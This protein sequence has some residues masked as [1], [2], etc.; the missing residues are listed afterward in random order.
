MMKRAFILSV[1]LLAVLSACEG[2]LWGRL[3]TAP[4]RVPPTPGFTPSAENPSPVPYG[5]ATAIS[6][7]TQVR[8]SPLPPTLTLEPQAWK[9]M[10]VVPQVSERM[11]AVYRAGLAA[12]RDPARFSKIGDCQNITTYFLADFDHPGEYRLGS[13]YASLQPTIDH[14]SGSWSRESLAVKGGMGVA[15]VLDPY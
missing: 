14:F 7:P 8:S 11:Q 4:L 13:Q 6:H 2:P 1:C 5:A 12:G 10:P 9:T 15:S 3:P